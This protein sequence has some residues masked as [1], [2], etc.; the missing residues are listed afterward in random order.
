MNRYIACYKLSTQKQGKSGLGLEAQR[1][2][3]QRFVNDFQR[4][5]AEYTDI[6]GGKKDQRP[7]LLKAIEQAKQENAILLI[8]KLDRL[9]RN[10]TLIFTLRDSDVDLVC[11]DMP[12]ANKVTVGIMAVLAQN[13]RADQSKN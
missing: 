9:S 7:N 10:A 2:H 3:V 13:E 8:A 1:T 5:L 12:D 6:E 4:V 11:C